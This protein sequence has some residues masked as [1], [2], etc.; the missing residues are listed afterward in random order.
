MTILLWGDSISIG[1]KETGEEA[2]RVSL[3]WQDEG[4]YGKVV[5]RE[6][7]QIEEHIPMHTESGL[8]RTMSI[9]ERKSVTWHSH[10]VD[11]VTFSEVNL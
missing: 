11:G 9:K 3:S 8:A 1:Q 4:I 7:K 5:N 2:E 10:Q 6:E